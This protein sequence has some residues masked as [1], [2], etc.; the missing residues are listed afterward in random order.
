[1]PAA[2]RGQQHSYITSTS[3]Q[4]K[5]I[6][7]GYTVRVCTVRLL[8]HCG[9][10]KCNPDRMCDRM[11]RKLHKKWR[12]QL[13]DDLLNGKMHLVK[14]MWTFL[15]NLLTEGTITIKLQDTRCN[16]NLCW[17]RCCKS[18]GY[19]CYNSWKCVLQITNIMLLQLII[20]LSCINSIS[21]SM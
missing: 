14:K 20:C 11:C 19:F 17:I 3:L 4:P 15:D 10:R 5:Y 12:E 21:T 2:P 13:I 1:M 9:D 8:S 18:C 16:W 6:W 7:K